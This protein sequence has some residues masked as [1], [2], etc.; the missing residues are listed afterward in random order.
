MW[1]AALLSLLAL[2]L[3]ST[4]LGQEIEPPVEQP[5]LEEEN[6]DLNL[7]DQVFSGEVDSFYIQEADVTLNE[8]GYLNAEM[9]INGEN[10][11]P[12]VVLS[13][14]WALPKSGDLQ[15]WIE[16]TRPFQAFFTYSENLGTIAIPDNP[17]IDSDLRI[18]VT[19]FD[20]EACFGIMFSTEDCFEIESVHSNYFE[21]Q[22]GQGIEIDWS[23][24]ED[25]LTAEFDGLEDGY[26]S[27]RYPED[28]L[29]T[30]AEKS[31]NELSVE[32]SQLD[33][34]E[35]CGYIYG[36]EL[37]CEEV[38]LEP[39]Q[40]S[41]FECENYDLGRNQYAFCTNQGDEAEQEVDLGHVEKELNFVNNRM[42]RS[43][44]SSTFV[45]DQTV[46]F[47]HGEENIWKD[48]GIEVTEWRGQTDVLRG[49]DQQVIIEVDPVEFDEPDA[50]VDFGGS[51]YKIEE[52]IGLSFEAFEEGK[53]D[54]E[55]DGAGIEDEITFD[56]DVGAETLEYEANNEGE[57]TATL[58]APGN[59]WNPLDSDEIV[60][61]D[62]TSVIEVDEEEGYEFG[63]TITIQEDETI[64]IEDETFY[65]VGLIGN[66]QDGYEGLLW[67]PESDGSTNSNL[68]YLDVANIGHLYRGDEFDPYG[69]VCGMNP[70][71][72]EV[73]IVI[74]EDRENPWDVCDRHPSELRESEDSNYN[75]K[76]YELRDVATVSEGDALRL[77]DSTAYIE[78][79]DS[80]DEVL[81][82]NGFK[83]WKD[84]PREDFY[85]PGPEGSTTAWFYEGEMVIATCEIRE[86]EAD[87]VI[88]DRETNI[89]D[90][91]NWPEDWC[92]EEHTETSDEI[93]ESPERLKSGNIELQTLIDEI[94]AYNNDLEE[95]EN[96]IEDYENDERDK[97][98]QDII[99]W[100]EDSS[101]W[102]EEIEDQIENY[103]ESDTDEREGTSFEIITE[104]P[105]QV[106]EPIQIQ[107]QA[108]QEVAEQEYQIE[109]TGPQETTQ[110]FTET[111]AE[112]TFT[113]ETQGDYTLEMAPTEGLLGSI[114]G[115]ITGQE[116]FQVEEITVTTTS[117]EWEAYCQEQGYSDT[118]T[119][120]IECIETDIVPNCFE[121]ENIGGECR[122]I[123]GSLCTE[124]LGL[125]FNEEEGICQ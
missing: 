111:E 21:D 92:E 50:S 11:H 43:G 82:V 115:G 64:S 98:L 68:E 56:E 12:D 25:T 8:D 42:T 54:L 75:M 90:D 15:R 113:L 122:D 87:I 67:R 32:K 96:E 89:P 116:T 101:E 41:N 27:L 48:A 83:E 99:D 60:S 6:E 59:W 88:R 74:Q 13:P 78:E 2:I 52:T 85:A 77:G 3:I 34:E 35:V 26:I 81:P 20:D 125:N 39:P 84:K 120:K 7:P 105:Y 110:Q 31:G 108:T 79:L 24:S 72:D 62:E 94:E 44:R 19:E 33:K 40:S 80:S 109:I 47:A 18:H 123:G 102:R 55:V 58:T 91:A 118:I 121:T 30:S 69:Y 86:N 71:N 61:T 107:T 9:L 51:E 38:E 23:E 114:I 28:E 16:E 53:Y 29:I 104:T 14:G 73:E 22:V 119:E 117:S 4:G 103:E 57:V 45:S 5:E 46:A 65:S 17:S 97:S 95:L 63:D 49:R 70:E 1:K 124:V 76:E 106:N 10:S 100:I 112:M 66:D 93:P 36:V 37:D